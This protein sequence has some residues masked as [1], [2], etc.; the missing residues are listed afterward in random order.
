MLLKIRDIKEDFVFLL[1]EL[2]KSNET[3]KKKKVWGGIVFTMDSGGERER[4]GIGA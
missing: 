3:K 2:S 4:I 1:N